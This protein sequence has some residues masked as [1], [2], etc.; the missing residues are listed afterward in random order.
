MNFLI[1]TPLQGSTTVDHACVFHA[2]DTDPLLLVSC[3]DAV[4]GYTLDVDAGSSSVN[5]TWCCSM[6]DRMEGLLQLPPSP[7]TT[8]ITAGV[9]SVS[10]ASVEPASSS[11]PMQRVLMLSSDAK[12][13][14]YRVCSRAPPSP[15]GS[16]LPGSAPALV[17]SARMELL[18]SCAL[19]AVCPPLL[20]SEGASGTSASASQAPLP[21]STRRPEGPTWSSALRV[22]G[23]STAPSI[24]G[25]QHDE[26]TISM[27]SVFHDLL[28]LIRVTESPR[29]GSVEGSEGPR[30]SSVAMHLGTSGFTVTSGARG[31][32]VQVTL[33]G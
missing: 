25:R 18:S 29:E 22:S 20:P 4:H 19:A 28:H 11:L 31:G 30:V 7:T 23:G 14:L 8:A 3:H 6:L 27:V 13:E 33:G 5:E 15:S 10:G 2:T 1:S 26:S 9:D 24:S 17:H 12:M 32:A 16:A 21:P